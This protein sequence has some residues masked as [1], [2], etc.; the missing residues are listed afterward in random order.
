[1][2]LKLAAP[3]RPTSLL[4]VR[5]LWLFDIVNQSINQLFLAKGSSSKLPGIHGAKGLSDVASDR[6]ETDDS[7]RR[8]RASR[9]GCL[10]SA[11]VAKV[12][13]QNESTISNALEIPVP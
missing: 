11:A 1:M 7:P 4:I 6:E 9:H 3:K 8:D 13:A 10:T 5:L 2:L 12:I